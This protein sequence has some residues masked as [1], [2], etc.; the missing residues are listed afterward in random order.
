[1]PDGTTLDDIRDDPNTMFDG[2]FVGFTLVDP[3]RSKS[4][5]LNLGGP[6]EFAVN[7]SVG[8]GGPGQ[9]DYP[10]TVLHVMSG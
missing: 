6:G 5:A 3:G 1:M 2:I 8:P 7:C 10:A 9:V 4:V